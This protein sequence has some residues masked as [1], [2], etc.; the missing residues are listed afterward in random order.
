MDKVINVPLIL[1]P[2]NWV[3]VVLM[4][5]LGSMAI[6]YIFASASNPE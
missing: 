6:E 2:L 5:L 3:I 4:V 1:N